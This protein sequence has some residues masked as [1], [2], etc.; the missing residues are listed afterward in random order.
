MNSNPSDGV[1]SAGFFPRLPRKSHGSTIHRAR[2]IPFPL[3]PEEL[4]RIEKLV[5]SEPAHPLA[6]A[7]V[8]LVATVRDLKAAVQMLASELDEGD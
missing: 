1:G 8:S 4:Q 5:A 6:E 7:V 2:Q 3:I